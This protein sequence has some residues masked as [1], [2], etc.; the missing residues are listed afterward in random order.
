M[1]SLIGL[2]IFEDVLGPA[3]S[4]SFLG[5]VFFLDDGVYV[6]PTT[7]GGTAVDDDQGADEGSFGRDVQACC[8]LL[9]ERRWVARS[10]FS[11]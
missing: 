1:Y 8:N 5:F 11:G 7:R 2:G 6:A 4:P 3:N 9:G 10:H